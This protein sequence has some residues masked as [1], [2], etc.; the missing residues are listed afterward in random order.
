VRSLD[1]AVDDVEFVSL[2]GPRGAGK[3]TTFNMVSGLDRPDEDE[4]LFSGLPIQSR[5]EPV[6]LRMNDLLTASRYR[7]PAGA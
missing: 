1:L 2:V 5:V 6:S 7:S 4:I 3:A